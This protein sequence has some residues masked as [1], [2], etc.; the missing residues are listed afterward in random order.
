MGAGR[1][2]ILPE[3][4]ESLSQSASAMHF[5]ALK[6]RHSCR[7]AEAL[8]IYSVQTFYPAKALQGMFNAPVFAKERAQPV[9]A[10]R[11]RREQGIRVRLKHDDFLSHIRGRS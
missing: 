10:S 1:A 4:H 9:P 7:V 2:C 3:K 5:C 8:G 6:Y 11:Q